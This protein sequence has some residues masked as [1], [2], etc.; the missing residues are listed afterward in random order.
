VNDIHHTQPSTQTSSDLREKSGESTTGRETETEAE[1]EKE[2]SKRKIKP[3]TRFNDYELY[4]VFAFAQ[5]IRKLMK[6]P[7][8]QEKNGNRLLRKN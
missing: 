4:T 7:K 8:S 3:L 5:K 2:T 6:R 1:K